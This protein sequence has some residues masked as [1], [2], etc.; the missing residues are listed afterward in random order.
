MVFT[1]IFFAPLNNLYLMG[2]LPI[3]A[4]LFGVGYLFY[5]HRM[6]KKANDNINHDA[7][8][9]GAVFGFVYPLLI[10]PKLIKVFINGFVS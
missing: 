7:H 5:S 9:V 10:D 1:S 6:S 2:I 4:I 3:P 8:F